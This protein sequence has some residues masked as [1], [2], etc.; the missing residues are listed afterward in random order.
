MQNKWFAQDSTNQKKEPESSFVFDW[1]NLVEIFY[2][3]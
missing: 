3:A 1:L 2:F